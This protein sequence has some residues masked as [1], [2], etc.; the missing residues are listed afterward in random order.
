MP[1]GPLLLAAFVPSLASVLK[2]LLPGT[3]MASSRHS[4]L[5]YEL[6]PQRHFPHHTSPVAAPSSL[7]LSL[8]SALFSFPALIAT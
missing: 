8:H 2:P 5:D 1:W 7:S 6:H 3:C 4:D